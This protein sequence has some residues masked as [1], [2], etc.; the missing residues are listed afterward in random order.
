MAQ[1]S[2]ISLGSDTVEI[3]GIVEQRDLLAIHV[4]ASGFVSTVHLSL[5]KSAVVKSK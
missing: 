1:N 2:D 3:D 5:Q 4:D